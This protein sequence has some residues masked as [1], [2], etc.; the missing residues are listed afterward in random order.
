MARQAQGKAPARTALTPRELRE[1][2]TFASDGPDQEDGPP[3]DQLRYSSTR[4]H[5]ADRRRQSAYPQGHCER[6]KSR[7]YLPD[8]ER[9]DG[10]HGASKDGSSNEE[11]HRP[12][13]PMAKAIGPIQAQ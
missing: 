7:L 10:K 6:V 5:R 9:N 4:C 13:A 11:S 3:K 8:A 12:R 2:K 1:L